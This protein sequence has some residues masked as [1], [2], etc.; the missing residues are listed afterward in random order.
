[1]LCYECGKDESYKLT[2]LCFSCYRKHNKY[3]HQEKL[4]EE[5]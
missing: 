1:M 4:I 2:G 3:I 5:E